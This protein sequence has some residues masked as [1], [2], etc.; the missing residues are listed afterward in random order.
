VNELHKV[1]VPAGGLFAA[2]KF[3]RYKRDIPYATLAQVLQT[4]V[5]Q[6][7][8]ESEANLQRWRGALQEPLGHNGQLMVNLIPEL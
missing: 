2:S 1:L 5:R 7:L 6:I 3:D 8:A 4:L